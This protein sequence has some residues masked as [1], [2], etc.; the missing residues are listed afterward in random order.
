MWGIIRERRVHTQRREFETWAR[1]AGYDVA[2]DALGNYTNA[3]TSH[4]W[5]VWRAARGIK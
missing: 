5:I 3:A 2:A 1:G 4:A